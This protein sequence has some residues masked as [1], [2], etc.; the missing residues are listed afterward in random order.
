[1][2]KTSKAKL[3]NAPTIGFPPMLM[4]STVILEQEETDT[5]PVCGG[6]TKLMHWYLP[7]PTPE[8]KN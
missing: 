8:S 1:M 7:S 3:K 6:D 5:L 2:A 4:S